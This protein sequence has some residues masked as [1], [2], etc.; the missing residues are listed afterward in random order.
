MAINHTNYAY[1]NGALEVYGLGFETSPDTPIAAGEVPEPGMLMLLGMGL[2]GVLG[3][4][5]LSA[6]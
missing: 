3:R 1:Y 5:G 6:C 4:R 2:V